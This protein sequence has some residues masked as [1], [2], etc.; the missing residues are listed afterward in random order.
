MEVRAMKKWL[1]SSGL[2]LVLLLATVSTV[3]AEGAYATNKLHA[4]GDGMAGVQGNGTVTITGNGIV[5]FRDHAGD[6]TWSASGKG[7]R[8]DLPSGWII[9]AGSDGTFEAQGSHITVALSG[10]DIEL[11]ATGTGRA[12]LRGNGEYEIDGQHRDWTEN[13]T[14][15]EL[16]LDE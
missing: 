5:Y 10:Y 13:S 1:V 9:Y 16:G 7:T 8:R 15:I 3:W 2:V 14:P 12:V 11:W 4:W 6:A